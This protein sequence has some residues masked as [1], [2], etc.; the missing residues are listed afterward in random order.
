MANEPDW[1]EKRA[2]IGATL[3]NVRKTKQMTQGELAGLLGLSQ[4]RLS[5]IERGRSSLTAE[6]FLHLLQVLNL[7]VNAFNK[8][9]S[10][11]RSLQNALVRFG[12]N[13]L[14]EYRSTPPTQRHD[15]PEKVIIEVLLDPASKRFVT[16]LCP[17]L[18][19]S[20]EAVSPHRIQHNLAQTGLP[21]RFPWLVDNTL[22]ALQELPQPRQREWR[23]CWKRA[24][25]VLN[26]LPYRPEETDSTLDSFD[27]GIRSKISFDRAWQNA[28]ETSRSW[29]I[30]STLSEDDFSYALARAAD[31]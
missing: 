2:H 8:R 16:A 14:R 11:S 29:G 23:L 24:S 28:S 13:H 5:E 31:V 21:R 25:I 4:P 7:K 27:P 19:W 22:I 12:A 1:D 26:S 10:P 30:V 18:V 3:R 15:S 9:A 17:V 6:Q 20:I